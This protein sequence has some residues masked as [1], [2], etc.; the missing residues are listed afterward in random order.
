MI[1]QSKKLFFGKQFFVQITHTYLL[2]LNFTFN[3]VNYNFLMHQRQC[4]ES[5]R[6][7]ASP[8]AAYSSQ[9][10]PIPPYN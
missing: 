10:N 8:I 4:A 3:S 2:Q 5:C 1:Y 7:Q 9:V 6:G